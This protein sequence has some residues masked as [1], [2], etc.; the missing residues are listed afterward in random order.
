MKKNNEIKNIQDEDLTKIKKS[1]NQFTNIDGS[2]R[3]RKLI[4]RTIIALAF[5]MLALIAYQH[6]FG[7]NWKY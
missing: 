4:I 1:S 3:W 7:S 6:F 5:V 2:I